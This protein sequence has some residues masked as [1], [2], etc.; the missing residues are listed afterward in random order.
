[1]KK[2]NVKKNNSKKTPKYGRNI[3]GET[4]IVKEVTIQKETAFE[5]YME[6]IKDV[7]AHEAK[8]IRIEYTVFHSKDL[9]TEE[10]KALNKKVANIAALRARSRGT[11]FSLVDLNQLP[12]QLAAV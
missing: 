7:E 3:Y 9:T 1:M 11:T 2:R 12:F 6:I 4:C 5:Q 8:G 10:A